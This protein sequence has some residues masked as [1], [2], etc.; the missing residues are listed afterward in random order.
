VAHTILIGQK[1]WMNILVKSA[2]VTEV[3]SDKSVL[4]DIDEW[5]TWWAFEAD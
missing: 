1:I 5:G 4:L 2:T 3:D